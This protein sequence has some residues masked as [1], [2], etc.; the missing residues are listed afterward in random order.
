MTEHC[1][2]PWS[3][4]VVFTKKTDSTLRFCVEY[5]RLNDLIYK[6]LFPLPK[7]DSSLNDLGSSVYFSAMDMMS[8]FWH[9]V[10]DP[11]DAEK[12]AFVTRKWQ[13]RF[14]ALSVGLANSPSIF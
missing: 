12:T 6:E 4:N 3:S 8:G 2:S 11:K 10:L 13:F 9:V 1:S 7:V 14:R 5:R